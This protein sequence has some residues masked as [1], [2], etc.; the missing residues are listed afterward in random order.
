[1]RITSIDLVHLAVPLAQPYKL[2]AVYGVRTQAE[3]IVVRVE[4]DRGLIG[5]GE[6]D[7]CP[8]FTEETAGG[9]MAALADHLGPPLIGRDP[10]LVNRHLAHMDARL[11]GNLAAKAALDMALH[12]LTGKG[13]GLP[14]TML[15]GGPVH[16]DLAVLWPLGSGTI[17]DD[18][19]VIEARRAEGYNAFMVK[20]GAADVRADVARLRALIERYGGEIDLIPDANQGWTEAEAL[21]FAEALRGY[22]VTLLEQPVAADNIAGLARVRRAATFPVSADESVTSAR[23]ALQLVEARAVDVFSVKVSKNGGLAGGRR[24]ASIAAAS[25]LGCLMNSMLE[26]GI[27][28]AASLQL[29]IATENLHDTG[30]AYMSV[31]R[32]ADDVTDF[33]RLVS[34]GRVRPSDRPGLGV[35]VDE[36]K[37]RRYAVRQQRVAAGEAKGAVS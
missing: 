33:G 29:G 17:E 9:V 14:A 30:H 37:L 32:M 24:I 31:L 3:A 16:A 34:G 10:T 4:T 20:M 5:W 35:E 28:Q 26:L 27:A 36:A 25:G 1:M 13:W 6:A 2:S 8:P 15:I 18:A 23:R 7:P 11:S 21:S 12:D 22:D 19:P